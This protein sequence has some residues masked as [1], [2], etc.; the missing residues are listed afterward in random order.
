MPETLTGDPTGVRYHSN[1]RR[2]VRRARTVILTGALVAL[3]A[4][5]RAALI[6][7][8]ESSGENSFDA[9]YRRGSQ[10]TADMKTLTGRF[11]ETTQSTLLSRPLVAS[12][13]VAVQ[14]PSKGVQSKIVLHYTEPEIRDVLIEGDQLVVA[15]PG[16]HVRDT[17]NIAAANRR[18]QKY[19]V[20]SSPDELR[21]SFDIA[22]DV[23]TDRPGTYRLTLLPKRKQ[24]REGLTRLELWID[25]KAAMLTAMQ[26]TFPNGDT[27]MMEFQDVALNV[28]ID[29]AVFSTAVVTAPPSR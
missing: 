17:T 2:P 19:F 23:P 21:K 6:A 4:F 3:A 18:I 12:G 7:Q 20:D 14:R 11:T 26:M 13:T 9:L 1:M 25:Q 29:P 22:D 28:P 8:S 16:R 15:W 24:I 27:K 10:I 5:G